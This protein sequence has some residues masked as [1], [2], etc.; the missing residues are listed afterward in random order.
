MIKVHS[1]NGEVQKALDILTE[2]KEKKIEVGVIVYTCLI[3]ACIK[4]KKI[5]KIVELYHEMTS[6]NIKGDSV[7]Y[8]TVISGL[9]FNG[10]LKDALK[11]LL[12][13]LE[14]KVFLN[15]E[16]YNNILKNV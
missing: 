2:M 4:H 13:S 15:I 12:D 3:Q 14:T 9:I 6:S 8:N 11:I 16:V 1:S 7:F 10:F 5:E